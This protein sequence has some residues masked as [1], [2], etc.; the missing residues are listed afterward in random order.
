[1]APALNRR[2]LLRA[3]GAVLALP[4][5][6]PFAATPPPPPR[7]VGRLVVIGGAEDRLQ[8]RVILRRF[9][10]LC[11]GPGARILVLS[12]ASGD[13]LGAWAAYQRVFAELGVARSAHLDIP[14]RVAADGAAVVDAIL[15]ADGIFISGGDQQRLMDLLWETE[16]FRALHTAFHLRGCCIGGT[17]AGAA[18]L[19]R[20][21]LAQG[22]APRL[23][24]KEAAELDIGLGFISRAIVDQHFSERG[25][26]GR[27]LS[28]LAQRPDMLGIGVDEDTALVIERG[29]GLEV[30][31]Q[32]AVTV[33]DPRLMSSNFD[34]VDSHERLELMNVRVH[35]LPAGRRYSALPGDYSHR[36]MP[37]ALREVVSLLVAPGP[38]RG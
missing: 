23:P 30:I 21:M 34:D 16:A 15:G 36:R 25:R 17:S 1:M 18:V 3:A 29:Q 14:D 32:G 19:S 2:R 20:H 33:V 4:A 37:A 31:G 5:S 24:E 27:L 12:A 7:R 22:S 8:D 35:L 26:L 9:A 38:I 13:P 10:G 28:V 11:G 6:A